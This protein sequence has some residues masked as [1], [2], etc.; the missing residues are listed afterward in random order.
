MHVEWADSNSARSR[1]S[2]DIAVR[3]RRGDHKAATLLF[4]KLKSPL[5]LWDGRLT[6]V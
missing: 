3:L 6:K 2:A 1:A 4:G 5:V